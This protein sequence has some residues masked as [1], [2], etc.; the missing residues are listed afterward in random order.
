MSLNLERVAAD[1]ASEV[2]GQSS[3]YSTSNDSD[4]ED[5]RQLDFDD[6]D[7]PMSREAQVLDSCVANVTI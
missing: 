5:S 3:G 4:L 1:N 2:T 7:V 6:E